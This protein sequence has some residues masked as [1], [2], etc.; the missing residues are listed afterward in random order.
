MFF[1]PKDADQCRKT[2]SSNWRAQEREKNEREREKER[3]D[4]SFKC[5]HVCCSLFLFP[6]RS[7]FQ[8]TFRHW[9]DG[10][11]LEDLISESFS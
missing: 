3:G 2:W 8:S 1:H 4:N 5:S 7:E 10:L 6:L 11:H 9:V